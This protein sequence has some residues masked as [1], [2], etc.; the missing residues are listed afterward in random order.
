MV[1][2]YSKDPELS[3]ILR[4]I[5]PKVRQDL[6]LGHYLSISTEFKYHF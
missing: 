1:T 2:K 4:P 3:E 5:Y 6:E